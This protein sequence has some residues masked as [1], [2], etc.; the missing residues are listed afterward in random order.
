[1]VPRTRTIPPWVRSAR[2]E[3]SQEAGINTGFLKWSVVKP[4]N[5]RPNRTQERYLTRYPLQVAGGVRGAGGAR[6]GH[7]QFHGLSSVVG[8]PSIHACVESCKQSRGRGDVL[9]FVQSESVGQDDSTFLVNQ[10][11]A[12]A[13]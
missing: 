8:L 9:G 13:V 5:T 2:L 11:L 3:P 10:A 12:V 6:L 4:Q 7:A 1:M